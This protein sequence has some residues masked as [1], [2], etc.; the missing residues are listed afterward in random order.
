ML[1]T[2]SSRSATARNVRRGSDQSPLRPA[3]H[4]GA[5]MSQT[6]PTPTALTVVLVHRTIADA[7]GWNG[8]G[9]RPQ[10]SGL[11]A[12]APA[13]PLRASPPTPQREAT[14]ADPTDSRRPSAAQS[15]TPDRT[16][17]SSAWSH[18]RLAPDAGGSGPGETTSKDS[19]LN[20]R[21]CRSNI[22]RGPERGPRR[23][24]SSIGSV[25]TGSP[26]TFPRVRTAVMAA[27]HA[28]RPRQPWP[29]RRAHP[30]GTRCPHGPPSRRRRRLPV[31]TSFAMAVRAGADLT[32]IDGSDV[33]TISQLDIVA[34]VIRKAFAAIS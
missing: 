34:D 18:R 30:P 33:F 1:S 5:L 15:A 16:K 25:T 12:V 28:P 4:Q 7:S 10:A 19:V 23:S 32:E 26:R 8:V 27:T 13:K 29:N 17:M 9:E 6:S 31:P 20:G 21:W 2:T 22:T 14:R 11:R 24:L 3:L